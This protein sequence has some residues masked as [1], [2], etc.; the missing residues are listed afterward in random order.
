MLPKPKIN[1]EPC[2]MNIPERKDENCFDVI[3][4]IIEN[5]LRIDPENILFH[6]VHRIGKP[7]EADDA[8]LRPIIARF[9]CREDRDKV[10]RIKNWL[11]KSRRLKEAYITQDYAQA[12]QMERKVLIKVMFLPEKKELTQR[13]WTEN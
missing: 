7:R 6:A 3:Y 9:L 5:E 12:I 2:F 4:D 1:F 10:Y 11:K 8:K 13:L